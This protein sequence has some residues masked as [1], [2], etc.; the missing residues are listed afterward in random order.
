M[1]RCIKNKNHRK[2]G[3]RKITLFRPATPVPVRNIDVDIV[4]DP[5]HQSL[6]VPRLECQDVRAI[7]RILDW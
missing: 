2:F 4:L 1:E 3:Y 7:R 6:R 5:I